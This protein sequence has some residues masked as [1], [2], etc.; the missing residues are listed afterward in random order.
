MDEHE[1]DDSHAIAPK[2][3]RPATKQEKAYPLNF[4]EATESRRK[5]VLLGDTRWLQWLS[6]E[7]R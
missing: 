1:E 6:V 5:K 2:R 7:I 4:T 3:G